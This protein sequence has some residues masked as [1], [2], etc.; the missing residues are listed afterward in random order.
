MY[1]IGMKCN[2]RTGQGN[3]TWFGGIRGHSRSSG[4]STFLLV[5]G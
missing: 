2:I 4:D 5:G 1:V 3:M